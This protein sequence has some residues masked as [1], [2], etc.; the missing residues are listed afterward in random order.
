MRPWIK[1]SSWRQRHS[2][3]LS[4]FSPPIR[5]GEQNPIH[6]VLSV[7]GELQTSTESI[8]GRG[9]EYFEDHL[10]SNNMHYEEEAEQEDFGL[11]S[12]ITWIRVAEAVKQ[13]IQSLY[14]WNQSLVQIVGSKS[15]PFPVRG[16]LLQRHP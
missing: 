11:V 10:I 13:A 9:K 14:C 3:K 8:V 12:L 6:M 4:L 7:G 2:S 16:V 15:D 1:T 5:R